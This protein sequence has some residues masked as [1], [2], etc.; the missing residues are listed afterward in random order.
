MGFFFGI[1][2]QFSARIARLDDFDPL[3]FWANDGQLRSFH[4]DFFF[5]KGLA[6]LGNLEISLLLDLDES[7]RPQDWLW[8][9]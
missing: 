5:K 4:S 2:F 3:I 1:Y 7:I 8:R 6:A 9:L